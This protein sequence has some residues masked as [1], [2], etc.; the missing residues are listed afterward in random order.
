MDLDLP[1][2]SVSVG[3]HLQQRLVGERHCFMQT[4]CHQLILC[5]ISW[6]L[7]IRMTQ[8]VPWVGWDGH[9][10][11]AL[12]RRS[13][14]FSHL[15]LYKNISQAWKKWFMWDAED[16]LTHTQV[17][18]SPRARPS[19][20]KCLD[21]C[22]LVIPAHSPIQIFHTIRAQDGNDGENNETAIIHLR[23]R[24]SSNHGTWF[25][26]LVNVIE[27]CGKDQSDFEIGDELC[28]VG[29][30]VQVR[31]WGTFGVL[32]IVAFTMCNFT[33][34]TVSTMDP[35]KKRKSPLTGCKLDGSDNILIQPISMQR[36]QKKGKWKFSILRISGQD[37]VT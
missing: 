31:G 21:L 36:L 22:A 15:Q 1:M 30:M 2:Q 14:V 16:G 35:H 37:S 4:N 17:H 5:N 23:I 19:P 8:T 7:V 24:L 28:V 27:I 26:R 10:H 33:L 25:L 32:K 3:V 18:I 6:P 13:E 11:G 20:F 12:R 9:R 34:S 29:Q